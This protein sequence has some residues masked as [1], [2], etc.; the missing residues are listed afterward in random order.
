MDDHHGRPRIVCQPGNAFLLAEENTEEM[1]KMTD[2]L[3]EKYCAR[4]T[5]YLSWDAASW[6]ISKKLVSHLDAINERAAR[7]SRPIVKMIFSVA[8]GATLW[9]VARICRSSR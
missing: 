8:S 2:L 5:I 9:I 7:D 6:H 3:R 1:I 4:R